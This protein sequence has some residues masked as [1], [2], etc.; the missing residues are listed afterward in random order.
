MARIRRQTYSLDQ[1][2]KLMKNETI[3]SD[4]ECQRLSG[5]WTP[6]MISELIITILTD[7]YMPAIIVGEETM[8]GV[9]KMWLIDGLQRSSSLMFFRYGNIRISKNLDD[10][11]IVYQR[12]TMDEN[13]NPKRDRKNEIIWESVEFDVSNKTYSQLPEELQDRFNEYQIEVAIH[14]NC[15]TTEISRY[16]KK[17]NNHVPMNSNQKAF[18]Y[19]DTFARE[20]RQITENR[21]FLDIYSCTKKGRING[22]LERMVCDMVLLCNYPDEYRKTTKQNFKWL[23]ENATIYNFECLNRLLTRLTES[24]EITA[25]T[26]A[27]FDVKHTHIFVAVF[28]SFTELG[29]ND[30]D[31]NDF[32]N[33][34]VNGGNKTVINGKTWSDLN[35]TSRST[36][37]TNVVHGK[38]DYLKTLIKQYFEEIIKAA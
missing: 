6:G 19:L 5:A 10:H 12:K 9:S 23:N 37:D 2:L 36:R 27:L 31:F 4:Q 14:Q 38:L 25:K 15:D 22:T 1:Y 16:V 26:K 30:R 34:F 3:R 13:G 32:L 29:R 11:V 17:Y 7:D 18:T 24:L 8:G 21:F 35:D 28:E 33:W 20:A